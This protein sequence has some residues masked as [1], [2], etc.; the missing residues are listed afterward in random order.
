[1]IWKIAAAALAALACAGRADALDLALRHS[2]GEFVDRGTVSA[3]VTSTGALRFDCAAGVAV[4]RNGN[5]V[6]LTVVPAPDPA[7]AGAC[8]AVAV[9]LGRFAAGT[10]H[11]QANVVVAGATETAARTMVVLPLAG[12]CNAEPALQPALMV[13]PA[14]SATAFAQRVA[15]DPAYAA[16]LGQPVVHTGFGAGDQL[17]YLT[18]PPL[19]DPTVMSVRLHETGDFTAVYRN[20]YACFSAPP[21]DRIDTVL[22]FQRA[23]LDEFFY[24]ADPAEIAAIDRGDVGAWTRTGGRFAAVTARGCA[25]SSGDTVV[26]RFAGR[27]GVGSHFFTRDRAECAHVEHSAQWNFEG[28]PFYAAAVR[29]D[30]TCAAGQAPLYRTWRPFG[31]SHHR[32]TTDVTVVGAMTARG[33]LAEGVAMC[34]RAGT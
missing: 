3:E 15:S 28:I 16:A 6:Q 14:T 5:D 19:V 17:A 27:P 26:Y 25:L 12:R 11:V 29:A 31:V 10:W 8:N 32:F 34:V 23:G 20:G 30:G 7:A 33:W 18:Y 1:M 2:D 24:T 21:P 4:G 9:D 13:A 22:E